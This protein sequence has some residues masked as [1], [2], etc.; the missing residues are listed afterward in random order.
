MNAFA[1][2]LNRNGIGITTIENSKPQKGMNS[3]AYLIHYNVARLYSLSDSDAATMTPEA[4]ADRF[5]LAVKDRSIRMFYINSA[6]MSNTAKS[7]ITNSLQNIYDSLQG[8]QGRRLPSWPSLDSQTG[9]AQPF[10][11]SSPPAWHKPLKVIVA[12][13]AIA[14]IALLISAFLPGV[15]I[16]VFVLGLIGSAG[17]YVLSKPII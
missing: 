3:L 2:I 7:A 15:L 13:G 8:D 6:P 17:L 12:L 1:D 4:I 5:Q 16:P 10:D 14:L 9:A 11:Y